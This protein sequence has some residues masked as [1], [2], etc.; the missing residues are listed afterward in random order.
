[1]NS[2][3]SIIPMSDDSKRI[4]ADDVAPTRLPDDFLA[5]EIGVAGARFTLPRYEDLPAIA[6]YRDQVIGVVEDALSPLDA[7][8]EGAWLTA[9]MV[10]NYVKAGLVAAP[11]KKQYN[12]DQV[13]S[14][15]VICI[16]KQILPI[17]AIQSLLRIQ[18]LSYS[19]DVAYNYVALEVEHAVRRAF[20]DE[21]M[22]E[23]NLART[24][25]RES[26]L[27]HSAAVAFGAKAYLMSYLTYAGYK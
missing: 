11:K 12:R 21:P 15:I 24:V 6:L 17:A 4:T 18:Q 14:L 23:E 16:F 20:S 9:S 5:S 2:Q 19:F 25:T 27:V 13:A 10:N 3:M 8:T 22:P 7:G 1:M 26:L